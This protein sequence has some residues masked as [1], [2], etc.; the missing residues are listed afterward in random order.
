MGVNDGQAASCRVAPEGG[1]SCCRREH[2]PRDGGT[3]QGVGPFCQRH[4]Q[5]EGRD[6]WSRPE[7][8][9][10]R[11]WAWQTCCAEGLVGAADRREAGP[12]RR[13]AGRRDRGHA[14][15][16]GAS[17]HG[18]A[19]PAK[20]RADA[21]KKTCA[22]SSRSAPRSQPPATSGSPNVSHS[23]PTC[24]RGLDLLTRRA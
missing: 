12:D 2:A 7:A 13:R 9:G 22:R 17:R 15:G 19:G 11:R 10:Q 20:P 14:R 21:Q 16:R 23:W 24:S 3:V 5:A 8:A 1:G 6:R 4:G 18:L